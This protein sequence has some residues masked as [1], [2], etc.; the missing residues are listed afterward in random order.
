MAR[1]TPADASGSAKKALGSMQRDLPFRF[2][3]SSPPLPRFL[4][5]VKRRHG[6]NPISSA[7]RAQPF[8]AHSWLEGALLVKTCSS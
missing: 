5:E 4:R 2:M 8:Q 1:R 6:G 7:L 3:Q